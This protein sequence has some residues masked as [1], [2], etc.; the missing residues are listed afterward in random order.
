MA[1]IGGFL[2]L[3]RR[4]KSTSTLHVHTALSTQASDPRIVQ[5]VSPILAAQDPEAANQY[6]A[7]DAAKSRFKDI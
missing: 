2:F 5:T 1:A 3:A 6:A 7:Q 4:G